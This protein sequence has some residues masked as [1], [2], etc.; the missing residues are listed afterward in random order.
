[1]T[2]TPMR[3]GAVLALVLSLVGLPV[4]SWGQSVQANGIIALRGAGSTLAA[5]LYKKWIQEYAVG[6]NDRARLQHSGRK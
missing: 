3:F 2:D 4:A 6:R 1:M 5:P